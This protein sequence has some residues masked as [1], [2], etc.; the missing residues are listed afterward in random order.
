M[1]RFSERDLE[2]V[3]GEA[4]AAEREVP[5]GWREAAQ[6]AYT[7]RNVEEEL[8]ALTYDSQ[9]LAGSSVRGTE[10]PRTL[11]FAA[12]G[13]TLEVEVDDGRLTGRLTSS[14]TGELVGHAAGLTAGDVVLERADGGTRPVAADASGFFSLHGESRGVVRFAVRVGD[15]RLVSEWI[16]L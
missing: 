16:Q 7:W 14:A 12:E 9:Q 13:L 1:S 3:L 11:E 6:A 8:L 5:D 10:E 2:T 15:T 4:L